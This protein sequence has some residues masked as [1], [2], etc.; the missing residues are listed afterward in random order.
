MA[1]RDGVPELVIGLSAVLGIVCLVGLGGSVRSILKT[2]ATM[3]ENR[4]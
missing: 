3:T 1:D 2:D 4:R